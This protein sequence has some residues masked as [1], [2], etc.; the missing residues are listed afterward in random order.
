M[1]MFINEGCEAS[2]RGTSKHDLDGTLPLK[3]E[4]IYLKL[5]IY[6]LLLFE[7]KRGLLR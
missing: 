2:R 4:L 6:Y 3:A 7:L 1:I 5:F